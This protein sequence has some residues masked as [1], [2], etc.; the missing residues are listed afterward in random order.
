[1]KVDAL[2]SVLGIPVTAEAD[3]LEPLKGVSARDAKSVLSSLTPAR[4]RFL[5]WIFDKFEIE[6]RDLPDVPHSR[7]DWRA[8]RESGCGYCCK[9]CARV[10]AALVSSAAKS[11]GVEAHPS[12]LRAMAEDATRP[13][14]A[15]GSP[16]SARSVSRRAAGAS[17]QLAAVQWAASD[18]AD[19]SAR[20]L[21]AIA[22]PSS[23]RPGLARDL[24]V[25]MGRRP[26]SARE[27]RAAA[28]PTTAAPRPAIALA[29][30]QVH[31]SASTAAGM[32]LFDAMDDTGR[33]M[34]EDD[35]LEAPETL[36]VI[37]QQRLPALPR[38]VAVCAAGSA[39]GSG[40]A[41]GG[42]AGGG[43]CVCVCGGGVT[44]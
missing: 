24:C 22:R 23:A 20:A 40:R 19:A 39:P 9:R 42:A 17:L 43:V 27:T 5:V 37:M 29:S 18:D 12:V 2:T 1:M 4:R 13:R 34:L 6:T 11:C 26:A 30:S 14:A 15:P 25:P 21:R 38:T 7:A 33:L 10:T 41:S 35:A 3:F 8:V 32:S 31:R 28:D 16:A 36:S 44:M